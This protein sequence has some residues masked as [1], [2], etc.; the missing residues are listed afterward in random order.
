M[1]DMP[2]SVLLVEDDSDIAELIRVNLLELGV[3]TIVQEQGDKAL[4]MALD[5]DY[6][7]LILDVMLPGV[8][9][10][11]ICRQVRE[12]KQSQAIIMLTA[13]SSETDRVLGLELGADDYITKPFSVRELQAR[14]QL[15]IAQSPCLRGCQ[16]C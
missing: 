10:L 4:Q 15:T 11:D 7:L 2:D 3:V 12:Q 13:K 16:H 5:N 9:G 14:V 1:N 6:S 8:S